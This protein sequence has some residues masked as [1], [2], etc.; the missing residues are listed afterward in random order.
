VR[1]YEE[2]RVLYLQRGTGKEQ[3]FAAFSFGPA[4]ATLAL[5]IPAGRWRKLL[6][7]AAKQWH[8]P[9][10]ALA[11]AISSQGQI[12]LAVSPESLA[13]FAKIGD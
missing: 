9:G 5:P 7:S 10:A 6:D 12:S 11:D 4:A 2:Q 3:A 8:G 13:L 1:A